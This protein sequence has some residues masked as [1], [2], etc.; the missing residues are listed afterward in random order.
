M[1]NTFYRLAGDALARRPGPKRL[2]EGH[3]P[4]RGSG[5]KTRVAPPFKKFSVKDESIVLGTGA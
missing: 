4:P 5:Q 2:S 1:T 3:L